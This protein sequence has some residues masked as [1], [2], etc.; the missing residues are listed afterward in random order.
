MFTKIPKFQFQFGT[1]YSI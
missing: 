1:K